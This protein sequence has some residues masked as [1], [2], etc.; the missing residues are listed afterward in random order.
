M[1]ALWLSPYSLSQTSLILARVRARN[2]RG[3]GSY[4]SPN[5]AGSRVRVVPLTM[6]APTVTSYSDTSIVLSWSGLTSPQNGDSE[7]TG[8]NLF[9]D[10]GMGGT[11][12]ISLFDALGLTY[13]V[14]SSMIVPGTTYRF[15][16]RARNMYGYATSISSVVSVLAIDVPDQPSSP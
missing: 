5:T 1:S 4:S 15:A 7:I 12:T 8:Y 3:W 2:I 6:S 9:W 14:T 13:T 16:I 10:N 11:P